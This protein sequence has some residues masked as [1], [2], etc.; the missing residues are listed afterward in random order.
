MN[1]N[2][3]VIF[4]L[5][6]IVGGIIAALVFY[7]KSHNPKYKWET[8]YSRKNEQPY[9]LK[10]I[11]E[12]LNNQTN[13]LRVINTYEYELIDT[14]LSN[15]NLISID[16]YSDLDSTNISYLLSYIRR[17]NNAFISSNDLPD[18]LLNSLVPAFDSLDEY[19]YHN[20]DSITVHYATGLSEEYNAHYND[21]ITVNKAPV[22]VQVPYPEK[23]RFH[24]QY[25]K[26]T[27]A[28]YWY[29]IN[30]YDF[31]TI[32][33]PYNVTPISYVNDSLV[34]CYSFSIGKGKL[35]IHS[36]PLLFTN[37]NVI[38]KNGFKNLNNL[39]SNLN[40]GPIYWSEI[41]YNLPGNSDSSGGYGNNPLKFLFSHY[42]LKTGWYVFLASV[43]LFL[44]FRSKREQR[45][46][47]VLYKN[48]NT[49]IEYAKAV[50]SLY[51]QKKAHY[52]I[53]TELY[54]IF[55]SDI[56]S[57]Y[58]V[59]TSLSED[60]LVEQIVKRTEVK[61]EIVVDL[62]KSF[63]DAKYN[64]N[65]TSKELIVLHKALEKFNQLKK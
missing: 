6:L 49:S 14:T 39:F 13:D 27:R 16:S 34:N 51:Y 18:Y 1:R 45:I 19:S 57:R 64:I 60:D 65:S 22:Q 30:K 54:N 21:S 50:G 62:F 47:P 38:Q 48:K 42:T 46:I 24:H 33:S 25:L 2:N 35:I 61:K 15:S 52:Q 58:N 29:G 43:L 8:N 37:Y 44:L 7:V 11:F 20:G 3:N 63:K 4:L 17:G 56:R 5:I 40:N 36:T 12:L 23:L 55:L 10:Y 32:L 53:A 59:S 9:G 41:N 28:T 26:T 31:N